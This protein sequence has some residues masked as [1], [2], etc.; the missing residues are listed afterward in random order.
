M[1]PIKQ[2]CDLVKGLPFCQRSQMSARW[3]AE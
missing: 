1:V 3:L 2:P